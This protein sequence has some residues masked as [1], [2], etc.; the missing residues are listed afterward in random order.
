MRN[1]TE[2]ACAA[3]QAGCFV[4]DVELWSSGFR[5]M[6]WVGTAI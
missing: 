1:R 3:A 4:G 6:A 5:Y 2:A